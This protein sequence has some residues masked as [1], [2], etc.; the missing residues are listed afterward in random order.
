MHV[1]LVLRLHCTFI[2]VIHATGNVKE[3]N[4]FLSTRPMAITQPEDV[5]EPW[6]YYTEWIEEMIKKLLKEKSVLRIKKNFKA[7]YV[8]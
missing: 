2:H 4:Q 3:E 1:F 6:V 5:E 8:H 7:T